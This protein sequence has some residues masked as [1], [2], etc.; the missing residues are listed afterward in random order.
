MLKNLLVVGKEFVH[1]IFVNFSLGV[2]L[3]HYFGFM[4]NKKGKYILSTL[5]TT[6]SSC[7]RLAVSLSYILFFF[8]RFRKEGNIWVEDRE[9]SVL[10]AVAASGTFIQLTVKN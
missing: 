9:R 1:N 6:K 2:H 7:C 5:S 8:L 3:T 10:Q 4:V